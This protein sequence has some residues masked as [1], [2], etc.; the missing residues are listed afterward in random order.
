[1]ETKIEIWKDIEGYEGIYEMSSYGR[2]R[3]LNRYVRHNNR[4]YHIKGRILKNMKA[5]GYYYVHLHRDDGTS[6]KYR[7]HRLVA[8]SFIPNPDNLPQVNH[9]NE[10]KEDNRVGNLEWVT[11]KQNCNHGTRNKRMGEALQIQPR[12]KE[13]EQLTLDYKH[14]NTYPSIK[15]AARLTGIDHTTISLC[16]RGK[17]NTSGGY[18]WKFKE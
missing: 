14:L 9:K 12:C 18:R 6:Q 13:V 17:L 7:V 4:P 2:V 5:N 8:C 1:M 10:N 16:C 3:S 11:A 15:C